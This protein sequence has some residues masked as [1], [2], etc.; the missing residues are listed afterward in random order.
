[1]TY[2]EEEETEEEEEEEDLTCDICN[3]D[4]SENAIAVS[5]RDEENSNGDSMED[6]DICKDCL[7]VIMKKAKIPIQT[8]TKVVEKIIEKPV[9]KIVYKTIDKNGNELGAYQGKTKFD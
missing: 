8:E 3:T 5:L 2:D 4:C 7:K 6:Y 9:E 1:M